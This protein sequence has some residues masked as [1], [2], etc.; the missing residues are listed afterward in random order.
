MYVSI[1]L[2]LME[3]RHPTCTQHA[4]GVAKILQKTAHIVMGHPLTTLTIHSVVAFVNSQTFT[5]TSLR[6]HRLCKIL[7]AP[8][9]TFTHEGINM[10]DRMGTCHPH[11]CEREIT[12]VVKVRPDLEAQA[13]PGSEQLFTDWCCYKHDKL[14]LKTAYAVVRQTETGYENFRAE[15][16]EGQQSAQRAEVVA[17]TEALKWGQGRDVTIYTDSAYAAGA[18]HVEM[19]Q[20]MRTGFLTA[21]GKPIK[22]EGEMKELMEALKLPRKVAVV[23]CRG[24][25][26]ASTPVATGNQEADK[27]AKRAAGYLQM[28]QMITSE[29]TELQPK[30]TA[31]AVK[32]YQKGAGAQE[33]AVWM[34]RGATEQNGLWRGPDGQMVLPPGIRARA[35]REAHGLGHVRANQM[36]RNLCHWWHPFLADMARHFVKSCTVCS[37][38]NPKP[39]VSPEMGRLPITTCPGQEVVIDYT[40]MIDPVKGFRN[41]LVCVDTF[42]GWPEARTALR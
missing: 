37:H 15:Q 32:E 9:L 21:G 8:N 27:A 5:M 4:A 3:K 26:Q 30:L 41:L 34:Q 7:E 11:E 23:K 12:K 36:N 35:L 40:D 18:V 38:F 25:D 29:E 17:V 22:H 28:Y 19:R 2:D 6:Q 13:L 10:A 16:L 20:W 14:G 31:E 42:T 39:A 1:M 24:H 33:K